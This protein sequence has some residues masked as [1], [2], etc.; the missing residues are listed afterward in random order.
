MN[1]PQRIQRKRTK[2]WENTEN[3]AYVG[4]GTVLGNPF[5]VVKVSGK[6]RVTTEDKPANIKILT[7]NCKFQYDIKQQ[8]QAA[9]VACYSAMYKAEKAAAEKENIITWEIS[10]RELQIINNL[11]EGKQ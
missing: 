9:A 1:T 2:G 5:K 7:D 8:A 4:R 6:W 11:N 10:P 3:T